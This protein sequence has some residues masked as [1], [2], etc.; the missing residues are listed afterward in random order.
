MT[1]RA[2]SA[3]PY[4]GR[5][6]PHLALGHPQAQ[7]GELQRGQH[8]RAQTAL[9]HSHAVDECTRGVGECGVRDVVAPIDS[10]SKACKQ[11]IIF[12]LR[13]PKLARPSRGQLVANHVST[14]PPGVSLGS[15]RGQP[16]VNL[17]ATWCQPGVN[18][19]PGSAW[20]QPA[21]PYRERRPQ[22]RKC[23]RRHVDVRPPAGDAV[24]QGLTNIPLSAQRE[25]VMRG[26]LGDTSMF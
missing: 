22:Q 16:G 1:W 15:T 20:D 19:G 3:R 14:T 4:R 23:R 18:P 26:T 9:A 21:P 6:A 10:G 24:H 25:H 17:G 8:L 11:F 2:T 7:R 12:W 13:A 5:G